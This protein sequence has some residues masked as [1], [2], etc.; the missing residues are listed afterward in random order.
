[1]VAVSGAADARPRVLIAGARAAWTGPAMSL[2]PHRNAVAALAVGLDAPFR[3]TLHDGP[4]PSARETRAALIPPDALHRLEG[5]GAMVFAYLDALGD[6]HR[7]I[8]AE[9]V[10]RDGNDIARAVRAASSRLDDVVGAAARIEALCAPFGV[11]PRP[12][13]PRA[14]EAG[15]RAI[16]RRPQD[17]PTL[18][19]AARVADLSPSRFRHAVREVAG[20]SFRRYRLWRRMAAVARSL[21]AGDDLTTAALDAGFSSSA[22][23]SSSFRAM[24]GIRPS[25]LIAADT[26]FDVD[27]P[28]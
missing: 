6:D 17:F 21:A 20:T 27:A 11:A 5:R 10:E 9:R 8:D 23:L 19:R 4:E 3:L 16:D 22:H 13:P 24:F 18:E 26:R 7:G 28:Q 2:S 14:L 25:E 15:L 12:A 1:M